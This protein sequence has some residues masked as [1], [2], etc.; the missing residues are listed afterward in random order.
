MKGAF[1]KLSASI[2]SILLSEISND[3][4]YSKWIALISKRIEG[5]EF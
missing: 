1:R 3:I 5:W 4:K 2:D